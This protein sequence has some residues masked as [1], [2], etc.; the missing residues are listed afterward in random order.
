LGRVGSMDLGGEWGVGIGE[1][2]VGNLES[3]IDRIRSPQYCHILCV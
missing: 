2:G 3:E 1:W